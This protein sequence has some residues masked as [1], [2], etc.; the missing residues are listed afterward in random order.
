MTAVGKT[1]W[2]AVLCMT[3]ASTV[4]AEVGPMSLW[5]DEPA[6]KWVEALPIGNGRLG[7]MVFGGTAE[8]R[9]Q[10]NDD[11]LFSG[12]PHDYAHKG[13][14]KYLPELRKL[15][16]DGKQREAHDLGNREFMSI[17]THGTNRQEAYQAFGDLTLKFPGHERGDGYRRQLDIDQ[18]VASVEYGV[19]GVT[20]RR[21]AIAS[22]P[23]DAI[24]VRLDADK[25]GKITCSASLSSPHSAAKVR[26]A[27]DATLVMAGRVDDGK[28]RFEVRLVARVEGGTAKATDSGIEIAGADAATLIL[29]GASSFV[30]YRDISG[31]PAASNDATVK[32]IGEKSYEDVKQ[33]HVADHGKLFRR[34]SL[35]L[36]VTD[37]AKLPT[38]DRLGSFG[39]DDPQL[40]TLFFQFGRYLLIAS[41]RPGS[42]PANLQGIWND[43]LKP[44]WDSKWTI[45]IN[46]ELNYWPAEVLNLAECNEPLFDAIQDLT[47]SGAIVAKE[48]YGAR[49]WVTHHNF[50]LWRGAAPINNSNHGIWPTGG[51]WLCQHLW[52]HYEF[53]GDKDF[54]RDKAYPALRSSA[55]FFVDTLVEDPRSEKKWLVSGPSN[56]PEQGGLVMGPTMDHQIIRALFGWVI[57]GSRVLDTDEALRRQL[58]ALKVRIASNQVGKH[59]QLQEWLEDVDDPNNHHRHLSHLWGVYPGEGITP[60]TTPGLAKAARVSLDFRGDGSVGWGRAWQVGLYARLRDG[61]TA[62]DRYAKLVG[63]NAFPN[64]FNKCWD[65][66]D[67][68]FQIDGN[69]GGPT[70]VAEMLLQSHANEIHLLTALPKAL[71]TGS[72]SGLRARGDFTVDIRWKDGRLDEATVRAG[73][74]CLRTIDVVIGGKRREL[75]LAPG[76][77]AVLSPEDFR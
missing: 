57:E 50:D 30:S 66:R 41:S 59:G 13:A 6:S 40:A 67:K 33:E 48:H 55:L 23:A 42:Q 65:N 17:N 77:A 16:F 37:R 19:D 58:E 39:T 14:V 54:L 12:E 27:G 46:T 64:L 22:Y 10:F 36:G 71:A 32:K 26:A 18:A 60:G 8:A 69:F 68:I 52:W 51:A 34:V 2:I 24:V 11:T 9:Y 70:G 35:D 49:G 47:E 31:D 43:S 15:L 74:N 76:Q 75:N 4:L 61:D 29:V 44:P 1:L 21:E 20:F 56:S 73:K 25:S 3:T 63:R 62:F 45:N 28:T 72:V 5:Y 53:S 7:A 38:N